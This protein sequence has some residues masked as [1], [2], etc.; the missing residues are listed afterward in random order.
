M[1]ALLIKTSSL[2][3]VVHTLPA[4]TDA[5]RAIPHFQIDWLVEEAYAEIPSW[6]PAVNRV[7]PVAIRRWRKNLL[8]VRHEVTWQR[9]RSALADQAYDLILDAQG[10]LKS[11]WLGCMADG[12]RAGLDW[13]SVREPPASL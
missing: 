10:L 4:I 11:A 5:S 12:P 2:G 9:L 1:R 7:L 3:D 8:K 6:H 13:V